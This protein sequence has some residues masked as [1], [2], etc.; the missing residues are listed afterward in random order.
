MYLAFTIELGSESSLVL[1]AISEGLLAHM[2]RTGLRFS[3]ESPSQ[4]TPLL[5][6]HMAGIWSLV[7]LR[8]SN[9]SQNLEAIIMG[10]F[11]NATQPQ[12]GSYTYKSY[13]TS[14]AKTDGY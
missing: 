7:Q 9:R 4:S 1:P 2:H 6:H 14:A 11:S 10:T 13:K 5:L 12:A 3:Q 8:K